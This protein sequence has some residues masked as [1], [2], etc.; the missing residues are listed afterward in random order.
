MPPEVLRE[1]D[2]WVD[3]PMDLEE[4]KRHREELMKERRYFSET[5]NT[6]LFERPFSRCEH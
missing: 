3:L 6:E 5:I 2:Q 1:I 4:A